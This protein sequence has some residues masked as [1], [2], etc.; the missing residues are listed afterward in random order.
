MANFV[1]L[2]QAKDQLSIDEGFT[3]HDARITFL[4]AAS[5]AWAQNYTQ[6]NIGELMQLASPVSS[7]TAL[8]DPLDSPDPRARYIEPGDRDYAWIDA[9]S[10]ASP[11]V[12]NPIQQDQSA[13]DRTD[14]QAAILL[15]VELLFDRNVD[16]WELLQQTAESLLDPYRIGMGV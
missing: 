14:V 5:I 3:L 10:N 1:T 6:R 13:S 8:P 2:Q 9:P 7:P 11:F 4:I 15:H 16:N 12:P